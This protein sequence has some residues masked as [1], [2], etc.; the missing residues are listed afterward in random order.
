MFA[1]T[2]YATFSYAM[3]SN[4]H[5]LQLILISIHLLFPPTFT[6]LL[7]PFHLVSP[8]FLVAFP[9]LGSRSILDNVSSFPRHGLLYRF[10]VYSKVFIRIIIL[11]SL[12]LPS[13]SPVRHPEGW[14]RELDTRVDKMML[15][16]SLVDLST[17]VL[18][19]KGCVSTFVQFRLA[20]SPWSGWYVV[21]CVCVL[22]PASLGKN[23]IVINM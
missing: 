15:C 17:C 11:L 20:A 3:R 19:L 13:L 1:C 6:S 5:I 18:V 10:R 21:A 9:M 8:L 23:V 2:V 7:L 22:Y 12:S 16:V 4:E 14:T